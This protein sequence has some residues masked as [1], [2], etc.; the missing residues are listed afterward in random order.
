MKK[1]I[2]ILG[3]GIGGCTAAYWLTH[4]DQHDQ[5]EVTLY[6]QGWRLGGKGA[7]GRSLDPD[8]HDR[9]EEHGLHIWLGFYQNAFHL[10]RDAYRETMPNGDFTS[11]QEAFTPQQEGIIA[12]QRGVIREASHGLLGVLGDFNRLVEDHLTPGDPTP[13]WDFWVYDFPRYDFFES[14]EILMEPGD[15]NP[16]PGL[17]DFTFRAFTWVIANAKSLLGIVGHGNG[18]AAIVT[19][20]QGMLDAFLHLPDTAA[21]LNLLHRAVIKAAMDALGQL[22]RILHRLID[23]HLPAPGLESERA[24]LNQV[25]DLALTCIIGAYKDGVLDVPFGF[26]KLDDSEFRP[27]LAHHGAKYHTLDSGPIKGLYDLPFA[28]E[29][30]ITGEAGGNLAAGVATRSLMRI[31]F[32]YKGAFVFKMNAGMGE[33]VF[34]PI[35]ELL[36]KRGVKF[37]F[38]HRVS[39][40]APSA[41]GTALAD[42]TVQRQAIPIAGGYDPVHEVQLKS[43]NALRV[44]PDRPIAE[45][46]APGTVLP[47]PGEP[48]FD[49]AWCDVPVVDGQTFQVGAGKDFDAVVLAISIAGIPHVAPALVAQSAAWR[50]ML[51]N[52]KTIRTQ[53]AQ[54]WMKPDIAGLGW[55]CK[56]SSEPALVDAYIDP[57]NTWMDQS[58]ILNTETW[59]DADKPGY[60]AYF[61]GPMP[62]DSGEAVFSVPTYPATQTAAAQQS[63]HTFFQSAIQP[64]WP[65]VVTAAGGLDGAKVFGEYYRA[66]IDPSERYVLSVA[67]ST[68]FRL[69]SDQS[70]FANLFFAGDW[71]RN[72]LNV[73]AVESAAL[74][75]AQAARA[76]SGIPASIPGETDF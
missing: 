7:S 14:P 5:Y 45:R 66:N 13:G 62:N 38:F 68:R 39:E 1:K 54:L 26:D 71:T 18:L 76:I 32:G 48:N 52:V 3:G 49:S 35:Y 46:L 65:G 58:V 70:G 37:E 6:Q 8:L 9:S 20:L 41:D 17:S 24:R 53:C 57:L 12:Q 11:I 69:R 72:G 74:S 73:G 42:F 43:G 63:A 36:K 28:Y 19:I 4:P 60:L 21:E 30:G 67:G 40:L 10:L 50:D 44:W 51:A 47:Q 2:A 33:I 16:V 29:D 56:N 64:I 22:R 61:C 27:W 55:V 25:L 75:G 15:D 59:P 31:F 23:L 34:I